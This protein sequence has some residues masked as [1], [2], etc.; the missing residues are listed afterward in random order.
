MS[1]LHI[2]EELARR[3]H[4]ECVAAQDKEVLDLDIPTARWAACLSWLRQV[5]SP[6]PADD[7]ERSFMVSEQGDPYAGLAAMCRRAAKDSE[8]VAASMPGPAY[9]ASRDM[10]R[11]LAQ[12]LEEKSA[13]LKERPTC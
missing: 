8:A 10:C 11:E 6:E 7:D 9:L 3:C 5:T 4:A 1:W 13:K 2:A 12:W